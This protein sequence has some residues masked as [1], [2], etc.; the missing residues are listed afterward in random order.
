MLENIPLTGAAEVPGPG[1]Y[2]GDGFANV[3]LEPAEGRICYDITVTG[4]D[5]PTAAHIHEGDAAVA[6]PV[7]VPLQAPTEGAIDGCAEADMTLIDSIE[8]NPAAFYLNVHNAEF[9]N[10]ALR[11]Q[12]AP[13]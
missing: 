9:P 6:G 1:D 2:D 3:F 8:T 5:P 11:G 4:I 13:S 7:V 12:L 10:G